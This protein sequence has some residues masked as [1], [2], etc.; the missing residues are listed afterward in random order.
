[1]SDVNSKIL[2]SIQF[3]RGL[4]AVAVVFY[5]VYI[6]GGS[7]NYL[8]ISVFAR[9]SEPGKFGVN[10]F[11]VLSGF[12]ICYAH[13]RDFGMP[14]QIK[15]YVWRRF[16]RIYPAYWIFSLMYIIAAYFG[17]GYPDFSW[18][19]GNIIS[20]LVLFQFVDELSLPLKVGWTLF[21]EI[22]FYAVFLVMFLG[23]RFG[24]GVL[25]FWFLVV[26]FT[27][28]TEYGGGGRLLALWNINF[29]VGCV[30]FLIRDKVSSIAGLFISIV[31]ATGVYLGDALT[32]YDLTPLDPA[33]MAAM[34]VLAISFG[35]IL[36][37]CVSLEPWFRKI[38]SS[39]VTL[40]GDASYAIYLVHSAVISVFFILGKRIGLY[41][42]PAELLYFICALVAVTGGIVAHH[43][44]EKPLL[45]LFRR[46]R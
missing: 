30:V 43:L 21:Y 2:V 23:V 12:I 35:A 20:S 11:F 18:N 17:I 10:L 9:W 41:A 19:F 46:V 5:H 37:G 26:I 42:L 31:G 6:I 22:L 7:K 36:L 16:V 32:S 38:N 27:S 15:K 8:D 40:L 33:N 44:V 29:L 24:I 3:L 39:W 34:V 25:S 14:G 1:M 4:A 28:V 13:S 45:G